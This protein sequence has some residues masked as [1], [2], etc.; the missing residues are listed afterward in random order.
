MK[1]KKKPKFKSKLK[2]EFMEDTTNITSI[3]FH[4][5][6]LI[7]SS[8]HSSISPLSLSNQEI[9]YPIPKF[10]PAPIII[11]TSTSIQT[12]RPSRQL[13]SQ[14][15]RSHKYNIGSVYHQASRFANC[16]SSSTNISNSPTGSVEVLISEIDNPKGEITQA[17]TS[18]SPL[19]KISEGQSEESDEKN[20]KNIINQ[21]K[22][23]NS[24][25]Y[26]HEEE[27]LNKAINEVQ[28]KFFNIKRDKEMQKLKVRLQILQGLMHDNAHFE[29]KNFKNSYWD[30][31]III[32]LLELN[33]LLYSLCRKMRFLINYKKTE[34][35][36]IKLKDLE[37][38]VL[39]IYQWALLK[40][41]NHY[42]ML[43]FRYKKS[44]VLE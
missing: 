39:L 24:S 2:L 21:H 27:V 29:Y 38:I 10:A 11:N 30:Y 13:P 44:Q 41:A 36:G 34:R 22:S 17:T 26:N 23:L 1:T 31:Y 12:I 4:Q 28:T 5:R 7:L 37:I 18:L 32:W 33:F 3:L 35:S 8:S 9:K 20:I 42:L 6:S 15:S 25:R 40:E 16:I 19:R 43:I 14:V